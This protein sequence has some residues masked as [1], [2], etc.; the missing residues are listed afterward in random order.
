MHGVIEFAFR[1]EW[2]PLVE[3]G[4]LVPSWRELVERAIEANVFYEPSFALAAAPV[5]G[6]DVGAGVVWSRAGRLLGLF[7]AR[8]ERRRYGL[9][10]PLLVGWTHPYAP[11]GSPLVD[12]EMCEPVINAWFHYIAREPHFPKLVLLPYCP[13]EG[14]FAAALTSALERRGGRTA[15]FDAH[16]RAV[17]APGNER[18]SYLAA[19]MDGKKRKELRRQR[20]RLAEFGT[21]TF[22]EARTRAA[23]E[24]AL[25]EFFSLEARGW[26]GRAGTA[27]RCN[28]TVASFMDTAVGGLASEGKAQAVRLCLDGQPIAI[29][30]I[31]R[32]GKTAWCWKIAYDESRARYSPGVQLLLDA[33]GMLLRDRAVIRANSCAT[34]HHPMIDHV[35]R[36][37]LALADWLISPGPE[38]ALSFG[39]A[40]GLEQIRRRAI[41]AAKAVREL[42]RRK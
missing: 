6:A 42:A 33:T 7:P 20:R 8:V 40:R 11:L 1:V 38:Q 13:V 17:L 25:D 9:T 31:L 12:G 26:K 41:D 23:V 24:C 19:A 30:L 16:S 32:S 21:L 18:E 29:L 35:W 2:R 28:R 37:R 15:F 5:L 10:L 27:A 36:E 3:L 22:E 39:L 14:P 34:P 4:G